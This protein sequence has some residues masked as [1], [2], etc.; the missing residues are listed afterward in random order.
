M[1]IEAILDDWLQEGSMFNL[2]GD[3]YDIL[4]TYIEEK[5][6]FSRKYPHASRVW[7]HFVLMRGQIAKKTFAPLADNLNAWV[8]ART[9]IINQ[10]KEQ[11]IIKDIDA[12]ALLY[13]IWATTQHYADF[14]YQIT[15][16]NGNK[17][18]SDKAYMDK[19][20]QVTKLILGSIFHQL[21]E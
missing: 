5:M 18:L 15:I 21:R 12:H 14:E 10:W 6:D 3:P 13:M 8:D 7:A 4:K 2:V 20:A 17:R 1:V 16:L 11:G 9:K 19:R